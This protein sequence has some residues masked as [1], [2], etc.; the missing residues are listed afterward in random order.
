MCFVWDNAFD[1]GQ[2]YVA[3]SRVRKLEDLYILSNYVPKD[4]IQA[5]PD[6]LE[7]E[8]TRVQPLGG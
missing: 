8:R 6:A 1:K 5:A 2:I 4:R 3:L 7:F